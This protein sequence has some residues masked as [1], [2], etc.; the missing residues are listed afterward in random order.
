L[1]TELRHLRHVIAAAELVSLRRRCGAPHPRVRASTEPR[2]E[3]GPA[4]TPEE[5]EELERAWRS[6]P[7]PL[8]YAL[9]PCPAIVRKAELDRE[10]WQRFAQAMRNAPTSWDLDQIERVVSKLTPRKDD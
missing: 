5:E 7:P 4:L 1:S 9:G 3:P 10:F 2:E 8:C 6:N